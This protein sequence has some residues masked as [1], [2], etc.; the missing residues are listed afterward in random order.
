VFH[1][2]TRP[3]STGSTRHGA[4]GDSTL[5]EF[6]SPVLLTAALSSGDGAQPREAGAEDE[7][8]ARVPE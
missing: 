5:A 4:E 1:P 2:L 7:K 8:G 6:L 3:S